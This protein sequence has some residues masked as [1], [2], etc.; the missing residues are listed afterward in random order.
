MLKVLGF[1]APE[2]RG[3]FEP[4]KAEGAQQYWENL[5]AALKSTNPVIGE[6]AGAVARHTGLSEG[7]PGDETL[8]APESAWEETKK[9]G[10]QLLKGPASSSGLWPKTADTPSMRM[11]KEARRAEAIPLAPDEIQRVRFMNDVRSRL[12]RAD[13]F[14]KS[15][16]DQGYQSEIKA[17]NAA[18][19][20]GYTKR[21]LS[22]KDV[23]K[24]SGDWQADPR[25]HSFDGLRD[26]HSAVKVYA[27]GTP[28]EQQLWRESLE[29]KINSEIAK[30][31][32]KQDDILAEVQQ[33]FGGH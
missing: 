3:P 33:R 5:K 23:E 7:T 9:V 31:P 13:Q 10:G 14:Q 1:A 2:F 12:R 16:D 28:E 20:S 11:L 8:S 24:I 30:D 6:L 21:V 17:A 22:D 25:V 27:A 19:A 4:Q 32:R 15:G 18:L 29:K 26:W